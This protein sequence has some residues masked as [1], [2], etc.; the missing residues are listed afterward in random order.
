MSRR[1]AIRSTSEPTHEGTVGEGG[2]TNFDRYSDLWIH[3]GQQ[4]TLTTTFSTSSTRE[5]SARKC[6]CNPMQPP[7]THWVRAHRVYCT[8]CEVAHLKCEMSA[9]TSLTKGEVLVTP[10][11]SVLKS[12]VCI[13]VAYTHTSTH[14]HSYGLLLTAHWQQNT[15]SPLRPSLLILDPLILSTGS[16][17]C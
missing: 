15:P 8:V 1:A 9:M 2:G 3:T 5:L 7:C 11:V 4:R 14:T 16:C 12:R 13:C 10:S 6:S 17:V